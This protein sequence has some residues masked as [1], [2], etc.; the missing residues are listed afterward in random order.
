P[1]RAPVARIPD[2]LPGSSS[3]APQPCA[4]VGGSHHSVPACQYEGTIADQ[5]QRAK[6]TRARR[7]VRVPR[8]TW[9][10]EARRGT[11]AICRT[12]VLAS[13]RMRTFYC[14]RRQGE[15]REPVLE[16]TPRQARRIMI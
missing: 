5:D 11:L 14:Q 1:S 7:I 13:A 8:I 3:P 12:N 10:P 6:I 15:E 9:Q 4:L 16:L 2:G